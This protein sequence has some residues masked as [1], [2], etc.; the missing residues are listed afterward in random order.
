LR[1]GG[2]DCRAHIFSWMIF[3]RRPFPEGMF[4]CHSCDNPRCVN[5]EHIWPGTQSDNMRDAQIKGRRPQP[6]HCPHGHEYTPENTCISQRRGWRTCRE[7]NRQRRR[8]QRARERA[9][10]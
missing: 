7:C 10:A 5:P 1:V 9:S 3:H 4:G 8:K 6:T 2:T